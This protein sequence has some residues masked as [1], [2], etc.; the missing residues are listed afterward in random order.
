MS[1][2]QDEAYWRDAA[3]VYEAMAAPFTEHFAHAALDA[4]RELGGKSLLDVACGT[5]A[6]AE[7]A[8]RAGASV[9]AIDFSAAMVE[10]TLARRI[11]NAVALQMNG[12][13]L[14]FPDESFDLVTSV[15]GVMLFPDWRAGLRE[16]V[17]VARTGGACA[18][19]T[20]KHPDG[21][22][23]NLLL[24]RLRRELFPEKPIPLGPEGMLH[25]LQPGA[26]LKA[27]QQA[28]LHDIRVQ[29]VS[30]AFELQLHVLDDPD[31]Y[32]RITPYWNDLGEAEKGSVIAAIRRLAEASPT[33]AIL[34]I[35]STALIGEGVK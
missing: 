25:L 26:L 35:P 4:L 2:Y 17:R 23:I 32:F 10:R 18:I 29:E 31:R 5:G 12:Q 34:R 28:G 3:R 30:H 1:G 14:A 24:A 8:A 27:M 20:W 7:A 19:V 15:F 33:S 11:P 22:A 6:L 21:A 16:M 9:T 13:A